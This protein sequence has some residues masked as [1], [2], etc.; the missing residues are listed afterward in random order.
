MDAQQF[1]AEFGYFA[2]APGGVAR[3]RGL[4]LHLAISGRL[5]ERVEGDVTADSLIELNRRHQKT[6]IARRELKRQPDPTVVSIGDQPWALPDGWAWTRLGYVTNYGDAPKVELGDVDQD[7]W[8][9]ELEDIEKSTSRLLSKVLAR[10]RQFK[11]T[12]NGFPAGSVLYGKLRPYLDKVLIADSPGVC[13]TEINPI[14]FFE[15]IEA[16]YLRWYMKSPYF[17]AYANGSTYG[18]NLPR[19]GTDAAR[20]APFPFPP[21]QEQSR[22]VARVDELMDLC[23]QLE[24]QQQDRRKLQNSLRKST[25]QALAGAQSP[26]ELQ[27][28]WQRL[29]A[30]FGC[31][32]SE[33]DDVRPFRDVLFDL[34]LRGMLLPNSKLI[35]DGEEMTDE[36]GPLPD[37]WT[38][39]TLA[40]L[41]EYITSGSRGWKAYISNTGDSFIRSQDIRQD[42]LVFD[43][44]AFV[45]LPDRAEGKRT[46]VR[47]G[48]L[49]LTITGGNVGR[50]AAVPELKSKAYVSQH[51]ALIRL[52]RPELSEFIHYWMINAYGGRAFLAR[53][54]YGDKPGLNL[55]QVGSVPVPVPPA[56]ALPEILA[57]LRKHQAL[58]GELSDQ[59]D[60]RNEVASRLAIAAVAA[61][62]GINTEQHEETA[63]KAP[64]TELIAPLRLAT[65]PDVKAQAPLATI[66]VRH[67]G[68]MAARDLWQ[69]FG[70]EID[71]FY[72]QLKNEVAHGWIAEPVPALV[73]EKPSA[74][75]AK[76]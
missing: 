67:E 25:L 54:I 12:K 59:L 58:C 3:L 13:T 65:P 7:T 9:L 60:A 57:S 27:A 69:R 38:W 48:D 75:A 4:V 73:R 66:L 55:T 11:S 26:H 62:T 42:A 15:H 71:D 76:A 6:L 10:D 23:D 43:N 37:G 34:S 50:C 17:V 44:P 52:N 16:G 35:A 64:H 22:I 39:K 47:Q 53:Y 20:E 68:E 24:L 41:S 14:S 21:R 61:L 30:N 28:S 36:L 74:D 19:L 29:Q 56:T 18:M 31:L 1:L 5:T 8:V 51:V 32:F 33:P 49:L 45:T 63:V 40:E 46:L 2:N 72:A 70:G